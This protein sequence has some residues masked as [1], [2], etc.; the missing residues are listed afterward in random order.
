MEFLGK[1][2]RNNQM[3]VPKNVVNYMNLHA[4]DMVHVNLTVISGELHVKNTQAYMNNEKD[5]GDHAPGSVNFIDEALRER[6]HVSDGYPI[7][8]TKRD[9]TENDIYVLGEHTI[10]ASTKVC[11][12][13]KRSQEDIEKNGDMNNCVEK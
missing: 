1:I 4:G 13:C 5:A 11:F 8:P 3:T 9:P 12:V 2:L 7:S 6:G 10:D